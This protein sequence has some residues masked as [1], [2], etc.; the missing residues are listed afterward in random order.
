MFHFRL[1]ATVIALSIFAAACGQ[2]AAPDAGGVRPPTGGSTATSQKETTTTTSTS[3]TAPH[4][5]RPAED[6]QEVEQA[7]VRIVANG[8][9]ATPEGEAANRA[10]GGSGFV[11]DADG[12]A[13]TNNHVVTGAAYLDVYVAGEE[14]PRNARVV[15]VSE[16]SDLALIDI[17]GLFDRY[18]TWYD[19]AIVPSLESYVAGFPLGDPNYTIYDG[20]IAKAN[21][22]GDSHWA[23]ITNV[24]EHSA[25]A[26]GGNSGGPIVTRD[27]KV[28]GVHYAGNGY[29]QSYGI[30]AE[31][32]RVVVDQL[33]N[34]SNVTSIG[35]NGEAILLESG[36]SGIWVSSVQSG[37]PAAQAGIEP[38]D[39]VTRL[40]NLAIATDGT[41]AQYCKILRGHGADDQLTVE[42]LRLATNEILEGVINGDEL[43]VVETIGGAE[44]ADD[45]T[46]GDPDG[47]TQ[48]VPEVEYTVV[49]HHTG[50]ME[51]T[52]PASWSDVSEGAWM[53]NGDWVGKRLAAA[54]DLD[55]WRNGW[56]TAG[57]RF[58]ASS[59]LVAQ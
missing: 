45:E 51:M 14:E 12:L 42:V 10:G 39:I 23:S 34:G 58:R 33:R 16:C 11:I 17:D 4:G 21:A 44:T 57:A 19:G 50:A 25:D 32:A 37:S 22:G 43:E 9:F 26:L 56:G 52:V 24:I 40:E 7:V 41:M 27:A 15:A 53:I 54:S 8:T 48:D 59:Y 35:I 28:L 20:V 5:P 46:A 31:E 3:T 6:L 30:S 55:A 18:L 38:G 49:A 2:A 36:F 47:E 1:I 29:G 13:V